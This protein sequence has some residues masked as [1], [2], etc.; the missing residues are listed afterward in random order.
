MKKT[1]DLLKN[2]WQWM[3]LL[4]TILGV[5][6]ASGI[7]INNQNIEMAETSKLAQQAII[8]NKEIPV[9]QRAE[10]C[11]LYL[12]KG[13]DS[14]TKKLCEKVILQDEKL[15]EADEQSVFI[16]EE[17]SEKDERYTYSSTKNIYTR[18]FGI[19]SS[20]IT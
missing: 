6:V 11:D 18:F 12:S 9:I 8:W 17:G 13:F 2:N 20:I 14:Y 7:W 4:F 16:L 19:T 10:V 1:L 5:G 15:A 3:T